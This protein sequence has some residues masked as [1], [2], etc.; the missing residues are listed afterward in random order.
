MAGMPV[1]EQQEGWPREHWP[2]WNWAR[3]VARG[4]PGWAYSFSNHGGNDR[5]Q[6]QSHDADQRHE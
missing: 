2:Q 1:H 3:P 4:A 5:D 6:A